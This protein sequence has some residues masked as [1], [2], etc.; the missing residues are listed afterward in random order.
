MSLKAQENAS[1][2][3]YGAPLF[4]KSP[5]KKVVMFAVA[6][7][8]LFT[9][10]YFAV[11]GW[12]RLQVNNFLEKARDSYTEGKLTEAKRVYQRVLVLNPASADANFGLGLIEGTK[13]P[14]RAIKFYKKA[15]ALN[16]SQADYFAFTAYTY[17]NGFKD[18]GQ[19]IS[20]IKK[21]IKIDPKS[22][23]YHATLGLFLLH[24]KRDDDAIKEYKKA[25]QLAPD[26]VVA[27]KKLAQIYKSNGLDALAANHKSLIKSINKVEEERIF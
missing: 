21:A 5:A 7:L 16:P 8:L 25:V 2:W 14:G 18:Y 1:P 15:A 23:S 26:N 4:A 11:D 6:I 20:W 19:A 27:H 24:S 10:S 17:H 12:R 13:N 22:S 9:F 3:T